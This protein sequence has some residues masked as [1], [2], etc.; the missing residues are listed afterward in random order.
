MLY[1]NTVLYSSADSQQDRSRNLR[2][3]P[4]GGSWSWGAQQ[5]A[6]VTWWGAEAGP[7]TPRGVVV[8]TV[9]V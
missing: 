2:M 3:S 6:V 8:D 7:W 9:K 1:I 4:S 5:P